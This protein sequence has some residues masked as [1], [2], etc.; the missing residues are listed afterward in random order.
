MHNYQENNPLQ[1]ISKML[2]IRK[3]EKRI[4]NTKHNYKRNA[5]INHLYLHN[6]EN[7]DHGQNFLPVSF[8]TLQ[9]RHHDWFSMS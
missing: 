3:S 5:Q 9:D 4:I 8:G 2:I 7:D 6:K 1:K